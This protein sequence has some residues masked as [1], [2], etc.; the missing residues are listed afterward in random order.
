MT[1]LQEGGW[2]EAEVL[3]VRPKEGKV[4]LRYL[5]A[6][7][8][9]VVSRE[10]VRRSVVWEGGSV[11]TPVERSP[12]GGQSSSREEACIESHKVRLW[13]EAH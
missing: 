4:T 3:S 5:H 2:W 10:K 7:K 11:F 1:Y 9:K 13:R 12:V 6:N 8:K